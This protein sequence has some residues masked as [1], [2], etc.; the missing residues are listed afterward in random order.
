M[1][2]FQHSRSR[3]WDGHEHDGELDGVRIFEGRTIRRARNE[4][5][6]LELDV[7]LGVPLRYGLGFMLGERF[8]GPFGWNTPRAFGHVGFINC[9]GW[10]DPERDIAV[11]FLT[12][13]KP[14]F[15]R[16]LLPLVR[17]L[18]GISGAINKV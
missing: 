18:N 13:G 15:G 1:R 14:A 11:G 16:H 6:F 4:T 5:S 17:I 2:F 3:G 8:V 7:T 12:S 10:A 9:F